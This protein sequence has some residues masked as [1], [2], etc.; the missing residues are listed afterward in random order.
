MRPPNLLFI[1][2]DQMRGSALGCLGE[3]PVHTPRLDALAGQSRVLTEAVGTYPVCS[4]YRA[5]ML[6]GRYPHQTGV[7]GNCNSN[8]TPYGCELPG[9]MRCWPDVLRAAGY[10][11][12]YIGKWH[13]DA[14]HKPYVDTANNRG[15]PAWNEWTPPD[16]RHGFDYWYAR[17]THDDHNR[18]MY[19]TGDADRDG[20]HYVDQW[21]PEH[22]ADQAIRFLDNADGACRDPDKPFALVVSMNPPHTPYDQHPPEYLEPYAGLSD[23]DLVAGRGN[24]APAGTRWGDHARKHLRHYYACITGVDT[25]VGRIL[26]A[27]EARGLADDTLVVFTSDHGDCVGAHGHNTKSIWWEPSLRV[28]FLVRW[29]GRIRPGRDPLLIGAPDIAPTLLGLLG[30]ADAM[31]DGMTG[32]DLSGALLDRPGAHRPD[33]QL[34]LWPVV[35]RP[36][37]GARGV[38][39]ERHT[40]VLAQRER[41]VRPHVSSPPYPDADPVLLFDRRADP[42]QQHNRAGEE[43]GRV[44]ELIRD[45]LLPLLERAGDPFDPGREHAAWLPH[46]D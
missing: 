42:W 36:E 43:P 10:S 17:G 24:V 8:H 28:P 15:T 22:E 41:T 3:E 21:S 33:A 26:D 30:Q 4:P 44:R 6:A 27:L 29:P 35:A 23:E 39:T 18:P 1:F 2:P 7:L 25:Q 14:P 38:R 13:L 45:H 12:G 19:W 34:Y 20:F 40:L 46:D 5:M 31:P 9:D 11:L 37:L 32:S 16:R